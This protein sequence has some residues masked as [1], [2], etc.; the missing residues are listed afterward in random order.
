MAFLVNTQ[1]HVRNGSYKIIV[2]DLHK[3]GL[4]VNQLSGERSM[5]PQMMK[6][7]ENKHL[8][9]GY[10]NVRP[11]HYDFIDCE[12]KVYNKLELDADKC[13]VLDNGWVVEVMGKQTIVKQVLPEMKQPR[14]IQIYPFAANWVD[15]LNDNMLVAQK[16]DPVSTL[17]VLDL[18]SPIPKSETPIFATH[19]YLHGHMLYGTTS[20]GESVFQFCVMNLVENKVLHMKSTSL[21]IPHHKTKKI[22]LTSINDRYL[23]YENEQKQG[24]VVHLIDWTKSESIWN[25]TQSITLV[26]T[27]P[28]G[29]FVYEDSGTFHLMTCGCSVSKPLTKLSGLKPKGM[30]QFTENGVFVFHGEKKILTMD[31]TNDTILS[32]YDVARHICDLMVLSS[33]DYKT[34]PIVDEVEAAE[35]QAMIDTNTPL[36]AVPTKE[37][38]PES[39]PVPPHIDPSPKE[40]LETKSVELKV[41]S[42]ELKL[43]NVTDTKTVEAVAPIPA[44]TP[45]STEAGYCVVM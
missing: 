44:S 8:V 6:V 13:W 9:I 21:V 34:K 29:R 7:L 19:L 15:K 10:S 23:Y 16:C 24:S 14:V 41:G 38:V 12:G 31:V 11:Y 40:V 5:R 18:S 35:I 32:Q 25:N 28:D 37:V 2:R 36:I 27:S 42:V 3:N 1:P 26:A 39:V 43:T 17:C 4:T 30:S 45:A 22:T 33:C 20:R